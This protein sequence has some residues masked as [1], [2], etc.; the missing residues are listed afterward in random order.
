MAKITRSIRIEEDA[1]KTL[2][3]YCNLCVVAGI[4]RPTMSDVIQMALDSYIPDKV[5][6]LIQMAEEKQ[7]LLRRF[8]DRF[9]QE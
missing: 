7:A 4:E 8:K 2:E 1:W 9:P 3:D 6:I 5:G